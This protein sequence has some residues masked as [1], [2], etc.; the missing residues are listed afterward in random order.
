MEAARRRKE[1]IYL[2]LSGDEGK[3]RLVVLAAEVVGRWSVETAQ[4]LSALTSA[5]ALSVPWV[6]G[7][8]PRGFAGGVPCSPAARPWF[9]LFLLDQRPVPQVCEIPSA[10][11]VLRDDRFTW[12]Q[13]SLFQ[14]VVFLSVRFRCV[15]LCTD[16]F[17]GCP[18]SAFPLQKSWGCPHGLLHVFNASLAVDDFVCSIWSEHDHSPC[19]QPEL[20]AF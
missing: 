11:E 18:F 14:Q 6:F 16:C 3:A 4:F 15:S 19:A 8:R 9:P 10:H 7:L 12:G 1:R 2:E 17:F 5:R 20:R 13:I